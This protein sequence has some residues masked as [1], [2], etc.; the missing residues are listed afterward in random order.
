MNTLFRSGLPKKTETY[1]FFQVTNVKQFRT[2]FSRFVP[3]V[4]TVAQVLKDRDT[5][6]KHKREDSDAGRKPHLIPLVG[7]NI[8]FSH[9]GLQAVR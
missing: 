1:F 4:K 6:D 3:L 8:S 2:Q 9:F 7:V 5:I